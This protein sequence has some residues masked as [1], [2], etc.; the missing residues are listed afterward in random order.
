MNVA[1]CGPEMESNSPVYNFHKNICV[2]RREQEHDAATVMADSKNFSYRFHNGIRL[3]DNCGTQPN[4]RQA[5]K[6]KKK[7][8]QTN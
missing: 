8:T 3:S 5:C 4:D 2:I 7:N 1:E 6:K